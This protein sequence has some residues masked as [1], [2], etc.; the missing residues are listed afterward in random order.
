MLMQHFEIQLDYACGA[1]GPKKPLGM[2]FERFTMFYNI[3]DV[4][5]FVIP[6]PDQHTL[7]PP[8]EEVHSFIS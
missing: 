1:G 3:D 5:A 7:V 6:Y 4:H 8:L 2:V